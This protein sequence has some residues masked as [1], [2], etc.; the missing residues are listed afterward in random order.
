MSQSLTKAIVAR[1]RGDETLTGDADTAYDRL[2]VLLAAVGGD[3]KPAVRYGSKAV[4]PEY[5]C[6]VF[7][8]DAGVE[9]MGGP[10]VGIVT[11]S[12]YR[13]ELWEQ[14]RGGLV[15]PDIA[16]C[17]ELLIDHRRRAPAW[18]LTGEGNQVWWS[19]LFVG[20][21]APF[22]DP[23]RDAWFGLMAFQFVEARP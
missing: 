8:E 11:Q 5:P 4:N 19:Q 20:L 21:Q 6:V 18:T 9:A 7:W 13:F 1:L 23:A 10:D 15:I 12:I 16:D 2:A 17:L 14:G 22:Y 3:D